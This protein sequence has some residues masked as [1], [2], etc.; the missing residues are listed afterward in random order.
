MNNRTSGFYRS[1]QQRASGRHFKTPAVQPLPF[2]NMTQF[3]DP[4]FFPR[5][6]KSNFLNL[7]EIFY[8]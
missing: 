2:E 8:D 3:A 6:A 1:S 4:L 7:I 5:D